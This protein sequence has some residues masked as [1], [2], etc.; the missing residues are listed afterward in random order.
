VRDF[1]LSASTVRSG[2]FTK[3]EGMP[4]RSNTMRSRYSRL[5]SVG[6][7]WY[8]H[9]SPV[10]FSVPAPAQIGFVRR[11]MY[12]CAGVSV[13]LLPHLG[14]SVAE[15]GVAKHGRRLRAPAESHADDWSHK[16]PALRARLGDGVRP[17]VHDTLD[18]ATAQ[19]LFQPHSDQVDGDLPIE[20][21]NRHILIINLKTAREIG[22]TVPPELLKRA[23]QVIE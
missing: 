19:A 9:V 5:R 3:T 2:L 7:T 11:N 12:C 17:C 15:M 4:L 6:R 8:S 1:A 23:D 21:V 22:A 18:D 13:G 10:A 20:V 16:K 14:I